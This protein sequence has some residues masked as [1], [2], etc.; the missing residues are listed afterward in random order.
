MLTYLGICKLFLTFKNK[1]KTPTFYPGI[2]TGWLLNS[3]TAVTAGHCVLTKS[4][5]GDQLTLY[6]AEIVSGYRGSKSDHD[7]ES[8][9]GS[10]VAIPRQFWENSGRRRNDVAFIRVSVPFS[11]SAKPL[12]YIHTPT[13]QNRRV[14]VVGY[15]G[16]KWDGNMYESF[17]I[18]D[19]QP[20]D[21]LVKHKV[22]TNGG[23]IASR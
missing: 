21:G 6:S 9:F 8:R 15:P 11:T 10:I 20:R 17:Q 7:V 16:D 23:N 18:M 4:S 22:D 14:G 1:S 12:P 5:K 19:I 2:A 3:T 13:L